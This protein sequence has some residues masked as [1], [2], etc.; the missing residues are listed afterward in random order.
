[1]NDKHWYNGGVNSVVSLWEHEAAALKGQGRSLVPPAYQNLVVT[2][3]MLQSSAV[4]C[5]PGAGICPLVLVKVS[6]SWGNPESSVLG[7]SRDWAASGSQSLSTEPRLTLMGSHSPS[8]AVK[9]CLHYVCC[10]HPPLG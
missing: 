10:Q 2:Y 4:P 1:M 7:I 8:G 5:K 3:L 6:L 9:C